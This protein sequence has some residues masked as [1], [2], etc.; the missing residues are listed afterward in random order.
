MPTKPPF[1]D[2]TYEMGARTF[3][4]RVPILP[5]SADELAICDQ[6]WEGLRQFNKPF[7]TA[8]G[9]HDPVTA[10]GDKP[11]QKYVPGAQGQNHTTIRGGHFTQDDNPEELSQIVLQF[12]ADNP[13]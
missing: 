5:E 4:S 12:M 3:P 10:G 7:I 11:L 13:L 1:P 9:T 6:A 2:A 8:F